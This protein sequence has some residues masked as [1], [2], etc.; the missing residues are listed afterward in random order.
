MTDKFSF[1]F[2][3]FLDAGATLQRLQVNHWFYTDAVK[4]HENSLSKLFNLG[5][6]FENMADKQLDHRINS[7]ISAC[8]QPT[9]APVPPQPP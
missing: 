6:E 4:S 2:M 7:R 5:N 1:V 3:K 8:P 9:K